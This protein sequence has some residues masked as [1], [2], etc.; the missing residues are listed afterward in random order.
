MRGSLV[1]RVCVCPR[2]NA[3]SLLLRRIM[4][5]EWNVLELIYIV[6]IIRLGCS[7]SS[8]GRLTTGILSRI[9]SG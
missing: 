1:R 8:R 7:F 3:D 2:I 9:R 4:K 6:A 5:H